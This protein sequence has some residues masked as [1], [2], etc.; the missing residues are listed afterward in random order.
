MPR[1]LTAQDRSSLIKLASSLPPGSAERKAILAGLKSVNHKEASQS[2]PLDGMRVRVIGMPGKG[3]K[4][5]NV[6]SLKKNLKPAGSVGQD[7]YTFLLQ[8]RGV[9]VFAE[10]AVVEWLEAGERGE[11]IGIQAL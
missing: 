10:E 7:S 1:P 5:G 3:L 6:Y 4:E 8:G 2:S 11:P 9:G